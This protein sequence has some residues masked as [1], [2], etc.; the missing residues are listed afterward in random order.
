MNT[1]SRRF[2]IRVSQQK[3]IP[4]ECSL[5][6]DP[7]LGPIS[8]RHGNSPTAIPL[9]Q[10]S[11]IDRTVRSVGR[12]LTT[13]TPPVFAVELQKQRLKKREKQNSNIPKKQKY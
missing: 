4:C 6:S 2:F 13:P 5:L 9:V 7:S 8:G 1:K 12:L 11:V 10:Q 3:D